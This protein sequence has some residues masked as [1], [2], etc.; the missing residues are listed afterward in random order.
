MNY[1]KEHDLLGKRDVPCDVYWGIHT[2]RARENFITRTGP[3]PLSLI[4]GLALVKKA[5][6]LANRELGYLD[7]R[8][9]DAMVIACDE[10]ISGGLSDQFPLDALQGGA[11]TSLNMNINEVIANRSLELLGKAKGDY[12]AVHPIEHVNMHQ[13]TNDVYPTAVKIASIEG[14]RRLSA[15]IEGL[16]Q[17]LQKKERQFADILIIGRTELQDAVPITLGAQFASFAEAF[18]RDRWRTFKCEERLRTVNIGGTAVGTGLTAPRN[19]IFLVIEKLRLFSGLGLA[20]AENPMDQ[21]ANADAFVETAGMLAAFGV[22]CIKVCNDLRLLHFSGEL[23]LPAVQAGSTIMPGKINPVICE[24]GI[25]AGLK[26]KSL[27]GL[28]ADAASM[29]TLQLCEFMPLLASSLLEAI[30]I[31]SSIARMLADHAAGIEADLITCA[32][33]SGKSITHITAFLPRIGYEKAQALVR[34][35]IDAKESN[36]RLFLEN[37]LGKNMV[38]E[39]LSPQN[40]MSLGYK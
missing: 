5:C 17:S 18:A 33:K 34:E 37:K 30:S 25:S 35:F 9:A 19:Y 24:A 40:I 23:R 15:D 14:L 11:G 20:R 6:C 29:G 31:A 2:L 7:A 10:I 32:E 3:S 4:R 8:I 39:V 16:Q 28:V 1:R 27:T 13:S 22:N 21:T 12:G 38:D 36:F 26:I